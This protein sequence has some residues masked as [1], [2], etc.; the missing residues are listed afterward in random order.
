MFGIG[1]GEIAVIF[2]VAL[3]VFGPERMPGIA[4][5]VGRAAGEL[6][7]ALADAQT[8]IIN[9]VKTG[10]PQQAKAEPPKPPAPSAPVSSPISDPIKAFFTPQ[11]G[12]ASITPGEDAEKK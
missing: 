10:T 2:I 7:R 11:E 1:L 5:A 6:R 4:R 12:A 8:D 9:Q 3:L